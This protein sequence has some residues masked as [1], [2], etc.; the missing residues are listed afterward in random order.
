MRFQEFFV[1]AMECKHSVNY[2]K[3]AS[4]RLEISGESGILKIDISTL[5]CRLLMKLKRNRGG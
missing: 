2:C 5:V 4:G 1:Y 3:R